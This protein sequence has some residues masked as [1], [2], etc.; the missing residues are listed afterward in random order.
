MLAYFGF[1]MGVWDVVRLPRVGQAP[2]HSR[3]VLR[4]FQVLH[5]L[6]VRRGDEVREGIAYRGFA[7]KQ[8]LGGLA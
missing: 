7:A 6:V 4:V 5:K 3:E 2:G 1:N 8:R